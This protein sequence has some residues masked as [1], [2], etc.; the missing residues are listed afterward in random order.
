I[1]A[2]CGKIMLMPGLPKTPAAV[3]MKIDA[4]G[5]ISGLA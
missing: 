3:N 1:V 2:V 4:N 5:E